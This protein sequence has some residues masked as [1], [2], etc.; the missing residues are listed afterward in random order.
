MFSDGELSI[1][2]TQ[3]ALLTEG[4]R[5]QMKFYYD[6]LERLSGKENLEE[7]VSKV[8]VWGSPWCGQSHR[9]NP[10][11]PMCRKDLAGILGWASS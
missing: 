3:G 11:L 4:T 1:H 9:N 6:F 8:R 2:Q 5:V 7:T 10:F